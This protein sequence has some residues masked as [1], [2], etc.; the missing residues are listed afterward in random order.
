MSPPWTRFY[1]E[2]VPPTVTI[3]PWT[4]PDLLDASAKEYPERTALTFFVDPKLPPSRMTYAALRDAT[5]RFATALYQLGVRKGD[6][7]AIML[8]NC[9]QFPVVFFGLLRLGAIA[10]NINPLYV[11]REMRE[12]LVDSGAETIILL[13]AFFP[14]LREIRQET[15]V[16]RVIVIDA[17]ETMSFPFRQIVHLV[18]RIHGER[19]RVRPQA[20]IFFLPHLLAKYPP[21]PPRIAVEPRDVALFQYTGGTTG[22]PKAA[23]LSHFNLVAN[24]LQLSAWFVR[25]ERG[26]ETV[27]AAIP[28]FHVYGMTV[29]MIFGVYAG[30]TLVLVPRPRPIEGVM[31][32]IQKT[33]ATIFPG[34]PTL[35]TAINNHPD[36]AKYDLGS[37]KLCLSGS[38][39]LPVEVAETFE[40]LTGGRLVEGYGMTELSPVATA[41][42]LFGKRKVG[43]IGL[44]LPDTDVKIVDLESGAPLATGAEGELAV[45][46]PQVMLGYW[47]KPNETATAIR[48]GWLL[49]G[50]IARIDDEGYVTIVDRKKDMISASGLKV[51][52]SEVEKVLV[53]HEAVQEAV[54]AGVPDPYRGETVKAYLVLKPGR[55]ASPEQIIAFCRLHLAGFKVPTQVEFRAELPKTMIGKVLRR[56]LVE[57][58]RAKAAAKGAS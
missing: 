43:S 54:V 12:Q 51:L 50:D 15:A 7:V 41:N 10:V 40:R 28:F 11:S 32:L 37:V 57:E 2:G 22:I 4:L 21:S 19:V 39:P 56:V 55:T 44:P 17:A 23:M 27:M 13:D 26:R 30:A 47:N 42:P 8:P 45:K 58:E 53:R 20:D 48:D 33:G 5:L 34:V 52:P 46:G 35:Y 16:R 36:V 18:Q 29:C 9:P 3:P 49:T 6:R 25:A 1:E 31:R 38:A 24:T 14:R